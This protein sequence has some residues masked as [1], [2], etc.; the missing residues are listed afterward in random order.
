MNVVQHIGLAKKMS[1]HPNEL[2]VNVKHVGITR[3]FIG[4]PEKQMINSG[5]IIGWVCP[6]CD[7]TDTRTEYTD[8]GTAFLICKD[9]GEVFEPI[10]STPIF[11]DDRCPI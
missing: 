3:Q 6:A 11:P 4:T 1:P 2:N 7:G 8:D 10:E 9:C 5:Q